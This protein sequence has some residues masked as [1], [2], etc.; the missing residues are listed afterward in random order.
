MVGHK[1]EA[2]A[3]CSSHTVSVPEDEQI[4]VE[5]CHPGIVT[6]EEF[7]EVQKRFRK[8]EPQRDEK[9]YHKE[10]PLVG[11]AVCGMC[12]RSM[13]FRAYVAKGREY[14]YI[15]CPHAKRQKAGQCCK[16]YCREADVNEMI[17]HSVRN[18]MDMA[19]IVGKKVKKRAD[20]AESENLR[21]AK[22]LAKLQKD[23]EKCETERFSN[24]DRFMAGELEKD[25][26]Q[27]IRAEL[28]C[29][30]E[31]LDKQIAE[32]SAKFHESQAAA[33]DGV[34]DAV[35]TMKKYSGETELSREIVEAFID[36][37]LIYDPKH[38]EIRWKFPN[39][40][41]KFIEG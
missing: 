39:E 6:K 19:D 15:L 3:P 18:L 35:S 14:S 36:K 29:R 12:G 8:Q 2:I 26:Y 4:A 21:T 41:I 32:V 22:K 28:M 16:R 40:V 31:L 13:N 9:R 10:R 38:I 37:V 34:R 11:T 7:I 27:R 5:N 1:R 25:D 24:V 30:A 33:D 17:W 20:K 23:K